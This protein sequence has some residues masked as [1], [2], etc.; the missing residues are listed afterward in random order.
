MTLD[1]ARTEL[2]VSRLASAA[3]VR[4]AFKRLALQHHPDRNS[5][6]AEAS[7]RFRRVLLAYEILSGQRA[8]SLGATPPAP[9]PRAPQAPDRRA[10]WEMP[11]IEALPIEM[12]D[13]EPIHYPTPEEISKLDSDDPAD[14]R[15]MMTRLLLIFVALVGWLWVLALLDERPPP[16]VDPVQQ[17][18]RERMGRPW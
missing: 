2:G 18:I 11:F 14:P 7:S 1:D 8:P 17:K 15:K 12:A 6:T 5:G 4:R 16:P 3:D 9:R 10:P 13:G